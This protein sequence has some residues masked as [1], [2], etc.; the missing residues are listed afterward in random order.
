MRHDPTPA[1]QRLWRMLRGR[2]FKG[3]KVRR[4]VPIGPYIADF[5]CFDPRAV[6][7]CDGS[8]HADSGY[9]AARD[10]WFEAQGFVVL[11]FWNNAV[12]EE[13]E[14]VEAVLLSTLW[15]R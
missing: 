13:P 7:E 9:D 10:A 6:I 3:L 14:G 12:L 5:V 1:E 2:S 8:Q 11:R 15:R 4:Q